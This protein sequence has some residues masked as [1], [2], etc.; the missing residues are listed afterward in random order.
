MCVCVFISLSTCFG[1]LQVAI[2]AY[3]S[4]DSIYIYVCLFINTYK[5]I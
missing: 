3:C 2:P 1:C 4:A 5:Y